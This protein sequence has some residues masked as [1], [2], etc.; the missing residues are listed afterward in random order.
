V[1][2]GHEP[3]A[4]AAPQLPI[5]HPHVGHDPPVRVVGGVEDERA[6]RGSWIAGRRRNPLDNGIQKLF[7]TLARLGRDSEDVLGLASHQFRKLSHRLVGVGIGQVDLVH[8]GDDDQPGI[9]GQVVVGQALRLDPLGRVHQQDG[10]LARHQAPGHLVG[11]VDVPGR[12][13]QVQLEFVV[14]ARGRVRQPDGLGLD[15]DASLALEVHAVQ[16]LLPHL[17]LGH[18]VGQL[19]EPVGQCR[20][21]VIDMGH[22]AEVAD[23]RLVH[24]RWQG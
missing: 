23:A 17:A 5:D 15:G 4:L 22:D 10:P 20:L 2:V 16:V 24:G 3:D 7:D 1:P 21:A 11:E 13:D 18:G 19:E 14:G 6:K 12:I 8:G 9:P